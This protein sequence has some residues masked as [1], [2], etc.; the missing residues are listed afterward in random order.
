MQSLSLGSVTEELLVTARS[1]HSG[2]AA[3]TLH[4]GHDHF[5]RQTV[6]ALAAGQELGEHESPGEATLQVLRGH[7][8]LTVGQQSCDGTAGDYL[9]IPPARHALSALEDSAV[10]LTVLADRAQA[11]GPVG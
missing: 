3:Q 11:V 6:I 9:V 5:L 2:R 1:H 10:L 4:G 7:V 8:R